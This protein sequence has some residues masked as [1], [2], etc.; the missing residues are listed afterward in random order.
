L[1]EFGLGLGRSIEEL[2]AMISQAL[3]RRVP[4]ALE[5]H[6]ANAACLGSTRDSCSAGFFRAREFPLAAVTCLVLSIMAL[7]AAFGGA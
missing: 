1:Y 5:R 3:I 2:L 4:V 6:Q 7:G